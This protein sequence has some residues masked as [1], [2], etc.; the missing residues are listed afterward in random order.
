VLPDAAPPPPRSPAPPPPASAPADDWSA[1]LPREAATEGGAGNII[2]PRAR[3][4]TPVAALVDNI[5]KS[6]KRFHAPGPKPVSLP[7]AKPQPQAIHPRPG[8][9]LSAAALNHALGG[10]APQRPILGGPA[11]VAARYAPAIGGIP[12]GRR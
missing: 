3:P 9:T 7:K 2:V 1:R 8:W 10:P 11:T 4:R 5:L 6:L 12:E